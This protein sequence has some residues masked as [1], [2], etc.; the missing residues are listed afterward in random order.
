MKN[1]IL[2]IACL[3]IVVM[4]LSACESFLDEKP[5]SDFTSEGTGEE[6]LVSKYSN[7]K[8]AEAELLGVYQ[9]FKNNTF[10]FEI[11]MINDV[12]TDNCYVGGD[13]IDGEEV[14]KIKLYSTNS[15]VE[16]VWGEYL[17]IAGSAT[18]V[19]ENTK[20]MGKSAISDADRNRIIAEAKTIRAWAYFDMVR[21]WGGIPMVLQLIPTI[22]SENLETWYPI[23]YPERT[24]ESDVYDQILSDL[25]ENNTIKYLE[26][27]NKG[28]FKST[29]GLAYGLLAKVLASR[30]AKAERNYTKVVEAC[31]KV[32]G[33]GYQLVDNFDELWQADNK[34]TKESIFEVYYTAESPNW[35]EWVLL[36]EADGTVTWRRYCTPT[37]DLIAKFDKVND[38][39]Y[40]SSIIWKKAP[41]DVF[42]PASKYPFSYK[43]REKSSDIIYMRLADIMLIKAEALVELNRSS[44][45]IDIVNKIR[46]RAG[47]GTSSLDKTMSQ[48]SARLA[49]ENE[50]QLELYMEG[51]RWFD[52][53]RNDRIIEIMSKHKDQNGK[54]LF[55]N[56]AEFRYKWPLPQNELDKN[57]RLTQNTGY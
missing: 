50:R 36:K 45:A 56:L 24:P 19:I 48:S 57:T 38:T 23:M 29:K 2:K 12:Q 32:I 39:R 37:H 42:F 18:N 43:I 49:V 52:L 22:T 20:L 41:Y 47:L 8:D 15:K 11:Y 7:V 30:G 54:L 44:E 13:G 35:A 3:C 9:L 51:Q 46:E 6:N 21:I 55:T 40:A 27:T 1:N 33:E 28:A 34:Y 16:L 17:S 4:G 14:D 10:E 31:D 25:D 53:Q 5:Q 26:S